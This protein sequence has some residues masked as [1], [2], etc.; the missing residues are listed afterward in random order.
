MGW[1]VLRV[2]D[3]RHACETRLGDERAR[4]EERAR[5]DFDGIGR[6]LECRRYT[7]PPREE[8]AAGVYE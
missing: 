1:R 7:G 2:G 5:W 8:H 4:W 6:S 3:A